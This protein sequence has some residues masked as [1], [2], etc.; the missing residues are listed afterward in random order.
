[1]DVHAVLLEVALQGLRNVRIFVGNNGGH[2]FHD[3]H[4]GAHGVV[5]VGKLDADS[6][7][8]YDHHR[9][10][11]LGQGH[12]LAV[13]N[14]FLAVLGQVGQLAR[15]STCRQNDVLGRQNLGSFFRLHLDFFA[16]E[17]LTVA[18]DHVNFILFHEELNA[19]AHAVGHIA[20]ALDHFAKVVLGFLHR[21]TVV[22]RVLDVFKHLRALDQGL[23]GD[24]APIQ[25]DTAQIFFFDNRCFQTELTCANRSHISTGA[26]AHYN[27]IVFHREAFNFLDPYKGR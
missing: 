16:G 4:F 20:A 10:G 3:G 13:A 17:H 24:T 14:N 2:E 22:F 18:H 7:R 25:T 11:L 8:T 1:M 19:L 21:N 27:H 5:D 9:F 26:R 12:G 23:G 15:T 6:A